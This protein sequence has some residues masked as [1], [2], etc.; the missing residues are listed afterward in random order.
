MGTVC[1]LALGQP[2]AGKGFLVEAR[3]EVG[4][5]RAI[6][7]SHCLCHLDMR[8]QVMHFGTMKT[9]YLEDAVY[10]L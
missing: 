4:G 9:L 1:D 6:V 10:T 3:T 5:Q 7:F 2:V 8:N